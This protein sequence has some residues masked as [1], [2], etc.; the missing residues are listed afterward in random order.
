MTASLD[1]DGVGIVL[2][3]LLT[4]CLS[5]R[6]APAQEDRVRLAGTVVATTGEP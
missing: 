3:L 4:P 1:Q 2:V 6:T 5:V